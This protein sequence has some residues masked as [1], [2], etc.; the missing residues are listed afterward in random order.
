M[1]STVN[2]KDRKTISTLIK[3]KL[4]HDQKHR[5]GKTYVNSNILIEDAD[6][7]FLIKRSMCSEAR[8]S[9]KVLFSKKGIRVDG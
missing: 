6:I 2:P 5:D 1:T 8:N 3:G 4:K 7:S 9:D